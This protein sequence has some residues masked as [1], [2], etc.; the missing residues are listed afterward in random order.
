LHKFYLLL[1]PIDIYF[2]LHLGGSRSHEPCDDCAG[3]SC[4]TRIPIND[5]EI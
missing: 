2:K 4:P 1:P 5:N 3:P